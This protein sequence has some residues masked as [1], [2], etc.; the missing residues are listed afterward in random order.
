MSSTLPHKLDPSVELVDSTQPDSGYFFQ[1]SLSP[2][3]LPDIAVLAGDPGNL[4]ELTAIHEFA[5]AW[6]WSMQFYS[7]QRTCRFVPASIVRPLINQKSGKGQPN[8][9]LDAAGLVGYGLHIGSSEQL[10]LESL[11]A[12]TDHITCLTAELIPLLTATAALRQNQS[13]YPVFS[14]A[15]YVSLVNKTRTTVKIAPHRGV[16]NVASL[17]AAVPMAA[18]I[19]VAYDAERLYMYDAKSN[20]LMHISRDPKLSQKQMRMYVSVLIVALFGHR[21]AGCDQ[22]QICRSLLYLSQAC[23]ADKPVQAVAASLRD[24]AEAA[25]S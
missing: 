14:V 10:L 19:R 24:R 25:A 15:E 2:K 4:L 1:L 9:D 13:L 5:E 8:L 18:A 22:T 6:H 20:H 23:V 17:L 21:R 3:Y 16:H 12:Q 11:L 7:S